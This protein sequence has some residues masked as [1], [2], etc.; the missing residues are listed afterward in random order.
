[1]PRTH[2]Q[3]AK[4]FGGK[5]IGRD[6]E[7]RGSRAAVRHDRDQE[8]PV[9]P[10]RA[11]GDAA[12]QKNA[13]RAAVGRNAVGFQA[14]CGRLPP[15]AGERRERQRAEGRRGQ[16]DPS[17]IAAS[18]HDDAVNRQRGYERECERGRTHS[19][20]APQGDVPRRVRRTGSVARVRQANQTRLNTSVPFVPPNPNEFFNATSIFISRAVLAQ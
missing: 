6:N 13:A 4:C 1:M 15:L 8:E 10:L 14:K 20:R 3:F 7:R 18:R 9:R 19:D 2:G 5:R 16:R 11:T 17:R 12:P